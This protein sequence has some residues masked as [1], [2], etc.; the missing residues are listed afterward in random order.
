[1]IISEELKQN[2]IAEYI[3]YMWQT[4]DMIRSF[5][6]DIATNGNSGSRVQ[7]IRIST[8][9]FIPLKLTSSAAW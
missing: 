5:D 1:M 3:L 4:E 6:F 7:R 2:N 9:C 8:C